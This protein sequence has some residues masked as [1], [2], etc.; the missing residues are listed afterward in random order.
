MKADMAMHI[1]DD[2]T[3][4]QASA[5]GVGVITTGRCLVSSKSCSLWCAGL[6]FR[7][8]SEVE[9]AMAYREAQDVSWSAIRI[10]W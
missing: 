3:F 8:V 6:M 5:L 9:P 7:P 10:W 4:E 2:M 1:P